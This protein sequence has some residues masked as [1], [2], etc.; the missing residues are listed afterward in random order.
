MCQISALKPQKNIYNFQIKTT[1]HTQLNVIH[2][3]LESKNNIKYAAKSHVK[4]DNKSNIKYV[5]ESQS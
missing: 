3:Y 1:T 5:T 4:F 2:V